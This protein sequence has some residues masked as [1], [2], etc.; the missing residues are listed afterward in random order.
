MIVP[1]HRL[2]YPVFLRFSIYNVSTRQFGTHVE[3]H[4]LRVLPAEGM[5]V[6]TVMVGQAVFDDRGLFIIG[7][8][9]LVDSHF[10]PQFISRF[11]QSV[12]Q[13]FVYRVGRYMP[14]K[15]GVALPFVL[16]SSIDFY[17][18]IFSNGFVQ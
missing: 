5:A 13:I 1:F 16:F 18:N 7:D 15:S 11:Y 9:T 14:Q 12:D 6:H 10:I 2:L 4:F 8:M 17:I 3:Q